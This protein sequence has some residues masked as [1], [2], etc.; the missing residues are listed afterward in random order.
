MLMNIFALALVLTL[1]GAPARAQIRPAWLDHRAIEVEVL[2]DRG[3]ALAP[4]VR[5][6]RGDRVELR[7]FQ[8]QSFDLLR[9]ANKFAA[10]APDRDGSHEFGTDE[11]RRWW[12]AADHARGRAMRDA[13]VFRW[14]AGQDVS[15]AHL[16]RLLRPKTFTTPQRGLVFRENYRAARAVLLKLNDERFERVAAE[17]CS[18]ELAELREP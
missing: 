7:V 3:D 11:D 6:R 18:S 10:R 16:K 15:L 1:T 17:T 12:A 2:D 8:N 5:I 4:N 9:A 13:H 14:T